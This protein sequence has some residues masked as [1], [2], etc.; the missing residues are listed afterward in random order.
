MSDVEVELLLNGE[1]VP[2]KDHNWQNP[3]TV[4]SHTDGNFSFW[5]APVVAEKANEHKLFE[6]SV[7]INAPDFEPLNHFF[8]VPVASE[9]QVAGSFSLNRTFK[10]PDLYLFL[11][12]DAE[13]DG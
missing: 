5:P 8:K 1:L 6:Y 3:C 4:V 9:I 13:K 7:R 10:L 12:G 2:M 11:P